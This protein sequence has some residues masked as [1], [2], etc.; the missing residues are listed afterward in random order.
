MIRWLRLRLLR[1][2]MR[3]LAQTIRR[4]E[5]TQVALKWP[6]WKRQQFWRT[7]VNSPRGRDVLVD[8]LRGSAK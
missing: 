3:Q 8:I 4:I 2:R 7:V 6:K 5:A 1:R